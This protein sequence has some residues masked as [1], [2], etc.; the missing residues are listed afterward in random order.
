MLTLRR[1]MDSDSGRYRE[2]HS[3]F[4]SS[5][6]G[7]SKRLC[8]PRLSVR[9]LAETAVAYAVSI[10]L[11]S[12]RHSTRWVLNS[13][14]VSSRRAFFRRSRITFNCSSPFAIAS[15]SRKTEK[16]CC[17]HSCSALR[18]ATGSSPLRLLFQRFRRSRDASTSDSLASRNA[19]CSAIDSRSEEH[20]S[21]LQSRFDLV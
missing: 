17:I 13:L 8:A 9:K 21:E 14:E 4:S 18:I 5:R 1:V 16:L 15:P 3:Q 2:W 6:S 20:T 12:S 10:R 7:K 11:S 19:P